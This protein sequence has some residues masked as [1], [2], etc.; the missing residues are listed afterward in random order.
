[1]RHLKKFNEE[2]FWF[3]KNEEFDQ[4]DEDI[5]NLIYKKL[6][7]ELDPKDINKIP[8]YQ[9]AVCGF[10]FKFDSDFIF[11]YGSP[12]SEKSTFTTIS[13]N[14]E[15]LNCKKETVDKFYN[16]IKGKFDSKEE[17]QTS[18]RRKALKDKYIK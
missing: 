10:N 3:N 6:E 18:D 12:K 9:G 17:V 7:R 4:E 15:K 1:M 14:N 11:V 16:M 5:V 8:G 13:I 2:I